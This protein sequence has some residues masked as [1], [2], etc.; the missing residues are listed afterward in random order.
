MVTA[1]PVVTNAD[2]GHAREPLPRPEMMRQEA[3]ASPERSA[4]ELPVDRVELSPAIE[5]ELAARRQG[6]D[7]P[8]LEREDEESPEERAIREGVDLS[9][10]GVS[11][12]NQGVTFRVFDEI[13]NMIQ[14]RIV[15]RE[16]QEVLRAVPQDELVDFR[17][18]FRDTVS[19]QVDV[20]A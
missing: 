15:D 20:S 18:R 16:T 12:K 5:R 9:K 17:T 6:E 8:P 13:A 10:A 3:A 7:V 14:A 4:I 2:L 1:K 19:A 11:P